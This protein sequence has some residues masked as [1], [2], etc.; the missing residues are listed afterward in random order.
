M[1]ERVYFI[2]KYSFPNGKVY[3]GQ[4][5]KGSGRFG[6]PMKYKGMFVGK[7]MLKY[8]NYKKE[9]IEY[10]TKDNV[11]DRERFYIDLYDSTN[12]NKGYNR[13]YGGNLHKQLTDDLKMELSKAHTDLQVTAIEQYSLHNIFIKRWN[14]IKEASASLNIERT[15]I[16]KALHGQIKT[17]GGYI[18]KMK[19]VYSPY[20]K[21]PISQYDLKGRHVKDWNSVFEAETTLGIKN[22]INALN[23]RNRTAG[24]FQWKYTNSSKEI[25]AYKTK[26]IPNGR[27]VFQYDLNGNF[28]REWNSYLEAA[29]ELNIPHQHIK[30]VLV[31]E[32]KM[33]HSFVFTYDRKEQIE[34]YDN[35]TKSFWK[36][37]EQYTYEGIFV[38]EWPSIVTEKKE[39]NIKNG[40]GKVCSGIGKTAG[41]Y[42]WKYK[43]DNRIISSLVKSKP[44]KVKKP[45]PLPHN[46][47]RVAQLSI[48]GKKLNTFVSIASASKETGVSIGNIAGCLKG[49]Q[50]TAGGFCWKY[51]E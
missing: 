45:R 2:Y 12:R 22:I 47:K 46:A 42:Q 9:I 29:H 41:G 8:P 1:K 33:T 17:A 39:L 31:G 15:S 21:R 37:V 44:I 51:E 38:K 13:E 24:R 50:K 49:R 16:S 11:D 23:G 6:K 19:E 3:I 36:A 48:D 5:Y 32:R 35:E 14:S 26:R 27:H 40:I 25:T 7:A 34:P 10:C 43:D 30:R 20:N 28:I 4:T 18:W